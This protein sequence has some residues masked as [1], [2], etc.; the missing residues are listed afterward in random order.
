MSPR[1]VQTPLRKSP[2]ISIDC[3]KIVM[4]FLRPT[5]LQALFV[6]MTL[7][8]STTGGPTVPP[9]KKN[10]TPTIG[11][12]N[13]L[14][15][16]TKRPCSISVSLTES[17]PGGLRA[18]LSV[19]HLRS[20]ISNDTSSRRHDVAKRCHVLSQELHENTSGSS[21]PA[22][23][24]QKLGRMHPKTKL[25]RD[26]QGKNTCQCTSQQAKQCFFSTNTF[27]NR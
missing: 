20:V 27:K 14:P 26:A 5:S 6:L 4:N 9:G 1:R 16:A 18:V 22:L 23:A 7:G 19:Q 10:T 11:V 2:H 8:T 15:L 13:Y 25:P 3:N 12:R 21:V 24:S 17:S